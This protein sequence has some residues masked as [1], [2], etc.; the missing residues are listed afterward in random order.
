MGAVAWLFKNSLSPRFACQRCLRGSVDNWGGIQ[1]TSLF[2]FHT[3]F[4]GLGL[5]F[6]AGPQRT[7]RYLEEILTC[8]AVGLKRKE[9]KI[10][11]STMNSDLTV[12]TLG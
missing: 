3:R 6:V 4:V 11:P 5:G 9:S 10:Q 8:E 1:G 2:G 7:R 12:Q